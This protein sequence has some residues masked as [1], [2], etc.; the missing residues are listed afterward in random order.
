M[1]KLLVSWWASGVVLG[2][3]S[4]TWATDAY[5]DEQETQLPERDAEDED[6][7]RSGD[8]PLESGGLA[9][10]GTLQEGGDERTEIERELDE[11]DEKDAGRGLEFFWIS[12]EIGFQTL[13]LTT[14]SN[15][16]LVADGVTASGSGLE[17]GG[18]V[19]LRLLYF[20]LGARFRRASLQDFSPWSL[21][22]EGGLRVPLGRFEPY[23]TLSGGYVAIPGG[24]ELGSIG[25]VDLRVGGG[26][27]LYLSDSFSVGAC[28]T[29]DVLFLAADGAS[30][31]GAGL[32]TSLQ[33][34]L[35]F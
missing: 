7:D 12:G 3:S 33:L 19:G 22:A 23:G 14:F 32:T 34:G 21:V 18:A 6:K 8:G 28:A 10:P 4:P 26:L 17:Y 25:G 24:E 20:T 11:S 9:A 13:G 35:H 27:D 30:S 15:G 2:A 1:R 5:D 31:V 16:G 29:G